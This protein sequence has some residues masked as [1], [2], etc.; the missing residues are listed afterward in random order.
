MHRYSNKDRCGLS[1]N[2]SFLLKSSALAAVGMW[3][4]PAMAVD[5]DAWAEVATEQSVQDGADAKALPQAQAQQKTGLEEIVVT[6]RKRVESAQSIPVSITAYSQKQI[7][8]FDLTSLEKIA[9]VT[10]ELAIGRSATGSGAQIALRGIGSNSLSIGTEQSVAVVV[11]G[12]YYGQGRTINEGFFDLENVQ[13]LKGPQ[14]LFFGKNATAGVI[15][16]NTAGPTDT[17]TGQLRGSYEFNAQ[18]VK[19]EGFIAGPLTDTLGFRLAG[20]ISKDYGFLFDNDAEPVSFVT[21]DRPTTSTTGP[22]TT[23]V[24]NADPDN[25]PDQREILVRGTLNWQATDKL[26]AVLKASYGKNDTNPGTFNNVTFACANGTSSLSPGVLCERKFASRQNNFPTTIAA[27]TRYADPDGRTFN[28]YRSWAATGTLEYN[29]D[30]LSFTSVTNYN[31]NRNTFAIDTDVQSSERLNIFVTENTSFNAFSSEMRILSS[32]ESPVNFLIGGYYQSTD[33]QYDQA[34]LFGGVENSQAPDGYRFVA[35][36]KDSNTDG[37]TLSGYGQLIWKLIPTVE[38]TGGVRYIHETKDS[39]FVHPYAAPIFVGVRYAVND[40]LVANQTFD[41]WSPEATLTWR[42]TQDLTIY[43]AYKTAYKSGGFSNS[44]IQSP[45]TPLDFF[46]F[47]AEESSGFEG[48]VKTMLFDRQLRFNVGLYT[49]N[50]T[51]LQ[52]TYLD[53]ARLSFN[54]INAGS[55][56]TK[57]VEVEFAYAPRAVSGLTLNGSVNYNNARYG[58]SIAPCYNGQTSAAGCVPNLLD[59]G[60]PGQNLQGKETSVAPLWTG[61]LAAD[62]ETPISAGLVLGGSV[63]ARY[64]GSYLPSPFGQELSRQPE[65]VNL[66]ATIRLQPTDARWE[67]ALI[68]KNLTNQFVV[69]GV[70]DGPGTGRGTGTPAGVSADQNGFV[71]TPRTAMLQATWHW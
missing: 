36:V 34:V 2:R 21:T 67:I 11:D 64:S 56:R 32:Y 52:V 62:Y 28:R 57:G 68:G 10:P 60:T 29:L 39:R 43:S 23:H 31:W 8:T 51:N 66:D 55:V 45:T 33:R 42:P 4:S 27:E 37:E 70:N 24:A 6:A 59:I 1:V 44:S 50:F 17:L 46:T 48:G 58:D 18:T 63:N 35:Y 54:S 5:Q 26:T 19:L 22:A 65:F 49:Y 15:S 69:T 3:V 71:N 53:S 25:G 7:D 61:A 9:A 47:D 41:N 30:H 40:P 38:A 20:R 13:I 14:A 12:V 16:I